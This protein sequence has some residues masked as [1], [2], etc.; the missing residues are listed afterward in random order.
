M[1]S[2]FQLEPK[3]ESK[4]ISCK[5]GFS[6]NFA[7]VQNCETYEPTKEKIEA[8]KIKIAP[9]CCRDVKHNK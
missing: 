9:A 2:G 7:S 5:F 1:L 4:A 3:H 6:P 8:F